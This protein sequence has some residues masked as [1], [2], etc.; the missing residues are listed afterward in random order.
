MNFESV[1]DYNI[2]IGFHFLFYLQ[3]EVIFQCNSFLYRF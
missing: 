2:V 3:F 1:F